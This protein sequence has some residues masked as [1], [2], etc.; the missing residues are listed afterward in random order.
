MISDDTRQRLQSV[1]TLLSTGYK[2]LMAGMLSLFVPQKCTE[3]VN[4]ECTLQDNFT[5]LTPYNTAVLAINFVTLA[6]YLIFYSVEYY[7]ENWCIEYLDFDE[8]KPLNGLSNDLENYPELKA[9]LIQVNQ[10]YFYTSIGV[11]G[12]SA[13]NFVL[14]SVLVFHYYYLDYKSISVMITY[15]ILIADKLASSWTNSR[16]SFEECI[17]Y[18]AYRTGPVVYNMVDIDHQRVQELTRK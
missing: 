17:P 6:S 14:S 1:V 11:M 13:V 9:K 2:M 7:R 15:A 10:A 12:M 16:K 8:S 18:S 5:D 4:N 3:S